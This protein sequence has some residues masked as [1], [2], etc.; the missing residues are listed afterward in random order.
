LTLINKEN[1]LV[2]YYPANNLYNSNGIVTSHRTIE[3]GNKDIGFTNFN[4]F[5]IRNAPTVTIGANTAL[6]LRTP[7]LGSAVN[8]YVLTLA[9]QTTGR[10]EWSAAGTDTSVY[11]NDGSILSSRSITIPTDMYLRTIGGG[12]FILNSARNNLSAA[13]N[14]V[15]STDRVTIAAQTNF[16]MRTPKWYGI[17]GSLV[18]G[19]V[20]QI[21]DVALGKIEFFAPNNFYNNNGTL[22]SGRTVQAN[23]FGLLWDGLSAV[24]TIT[25]NYSLYVRGPTIFAT[26]KIS[27][28]IPTAAVNGQVLT[29]KNAATGLVEFESLP[30]GSGSDY[31]I[32][33]SDGILSTNLV[34][35][36]RTMT[37]NGKR[38]LFLDNLGSGSAGMFDVSIP[39]GRFSSTAASND[40]FSS[41]MFRAGGAISTIIHTPG[42]YGNAAGKAGQVLTWDGTKSEYQPLNQ[43]GID[44]SLYTTNGTLQ[45]ARVVTGNNQNLTFSGVNQFN[46][47]GATTTLAGR[48]QLN[49]ITP[50]V[51]GGSAVANQV[52]TLQASGTSGR[53]E[54]QTLPV[55]PTV[56]THDGTLLDHR[57]VTANNKDFSVL[58]ARVFQATA[59]N[60]GL[61]TP[62]GGAGKMFL[63]TPKV[64][65]PSAQAGWVLALT[66]ASSG[67]VEFMPPKNIY[68]FNGTLNGARQVTL[69]G[70]TIN[71][72]GPGAI[73]QQGLSDYWVNSALIT[74]SSLAANVISGNPIHLKT[75]NVNSQAATP[76]MI[77]TLQTADGQ[78]E[79]APA[80]QNVQ[81]IYTT[82]GDLSSDRV[83]NGLV[84]G[85]KR[86]LSFSGLDDARF[87]GVTTTI[88]GSAW[89]VLGN[90]P[91][92]VRP[93]NYSTA[94]I[95][96]VLTKMDAGGL[97]EWQ[98]IPFVPTLYNANGTLSGSRVVT[99]NGNNLT[100][101]NVGTFKVS[102]SVATLA[103][104]SVVIAGSSGI[105]IATQNGVNNNVGI[106]Q[107]LAATTSS[108]DVEFTAVPL[109]TSIYKGSGT[110]SI[111]TT[112]DGT[113]QRSLTFTGLTQGTFAGADV[114]VDGA[115]NATIEAG[116]ALKLRTPK[117]VSSQNVQGMA[118]VAQD[119][120]G[121][122]EYQNLAGGNVNQYYAELDLV[123]T[124]DHFNASVYN[125]TITP[126]Y[127]GD[128]TTPP[129]GSRWLFKIRSISGGSYQTSPQPIWLTLPGGLDSSYIGRAGAAPSANLGK[130]EVDV[131]YLLD[132]IFMP[133]FGPTGNSRTFVMVNAG[134]SAAKGDA[135]ALVNRGALP[136]DEQLEQTTVNFGFAVVVDNRA[137]LAA[138]PLNF[139]KAETLGLVAV[140]DGKHADYYQTAFVP[141]DPDAVQSMVN[142]SRM[143]KKLVL[144]P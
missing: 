51:N 115:T 111:N 35:N 66:N 44:V 105:R 72:Q 9:D 69:G 127:T 97:A 14:F 138:L 135:T 12:E 24:T 28:G 63:G 133:S 25:T 22:T 42:T 41:G 112:V 103:A 98:P 94:A 60:I 19:D 27:Q 108:G 40:F 109:D 95:N 122:V 126:P 30:V 113:G 144:M 141:G 120:T 124:L 4:T 136:S 67:E 11:K 32:Y 20:P 59:T 34:N 58:G 99:G 106:G 143:W 119:N 45:G 16:Q 38:L 84:G 65:T 100:F 21:T 121:K 137:D 88:E 70:N 33:G 140:G 101:T 26:Q 139:K 31:S 85:T 89:T 55:V 96:S 13:T 93:P 76:G 118:L 73:T 129:E 90:G 131:G 47:D 125:N 10:A 107:V 86:D 7:G 130:Y 80:V 87:S 114:T 50:N 132:C 43:S 37:L 3:G 75:P 77:L 110:L 74:M 68:D 92:Y 39:N 48:S 8:N 54:W 6:N 82:S 116:T 57:T 5:S 23:G 29:L 128:A 123:W 64:M 104:Q 15:L 52:L 71:W 18:L 102:S 79:W 117:V 78:V 142:P 134:W 1:S 2:D 17:G 46:L 53:A 56:Y 81:N 91:I 36:T 49:V 62:V 61:Y 83:V